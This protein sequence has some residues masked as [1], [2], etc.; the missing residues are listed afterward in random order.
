MKQ[1][2]LTDTQWQAWQASAD[3]RNGFREAAFLFVESSVETIQIFQPDGAT[4]V[5]RVVRVTSWQ[6][7]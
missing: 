7:A 4:Q 1:I 5:T 6:Q 3:Y 2:T